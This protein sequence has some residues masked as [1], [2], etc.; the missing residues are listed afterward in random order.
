MYISGKSLESKLH[1]PDCLV[2][3][4]GEGLLL[5]AERS[6]PAQILCTDGQRKKKGKFIDN[7][8]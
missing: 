3:S 5:R 2:V 4:I 6:C 1:R 7:K 8:H